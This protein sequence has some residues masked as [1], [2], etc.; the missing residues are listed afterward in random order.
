[1]FH[2]TPTEESQGIQNLKQNTPRCVNLNV[3]RSSS[4]GI[5][6]PQ[7]ANSTTKELNNSEK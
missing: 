6:L 7:K 4:K 5:E 2:K 3:E 1:M